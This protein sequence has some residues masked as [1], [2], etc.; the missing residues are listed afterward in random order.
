MSVWMSVAPLQQNFP[1]CC[2]P[3]PDHMPALNKSLAR[4]GGPQEGDEASRACGPLENAV[5]SRK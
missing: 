1:S 5:F 4:G 3:E 2:W